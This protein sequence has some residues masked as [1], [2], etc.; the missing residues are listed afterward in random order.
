M[1][2]ELDTVYIYTQKPRGTPTKIMEHQ[3]HPNHAYICT[4]R[5]PYNPHRQT[6]HNKQKTHEEIKTSKPTLALTDHRGRLGP[7]SAH[8]VS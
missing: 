8:L 5:Q 3:T 7:A 6:S 4:Y 1:A 2:T